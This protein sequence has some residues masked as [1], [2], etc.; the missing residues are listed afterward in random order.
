MSRSNRGQASLE[1]TLLIGISVAALAGMAIYVQ[2]GYQGYLYS[3]ATDQ[4]L[5]FDPKQTYATCQD[6]TTIQTQKIDMTQGHA[7]LQAFGL[8]KHYSVGSRN[9]PF[10]LAAPFNHRAGLI[11]RIRGVQAKVDTNWSF[12]SKANFDAGPC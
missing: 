5:Q 9:F 10:S 3:S 12:T 11:G 7:A 8:S 1:T 2:R 4:G 6:L